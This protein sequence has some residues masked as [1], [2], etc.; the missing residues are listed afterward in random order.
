MKKVGILG[1]GQLGCMLA[2]ALF[3]WGAQVSF[4]DPNPTSPARL[5][6]PHFMCGAWDDEILLTRFFQDN[7]VVTYEFENVSTTLL[8]TLV[9]KTEVPLY[10]SQ[11]VLYLTQNRLREKTF[12]KTNGLPVCDFESC[13]SY[14]E[15]IE[16]SQ[17]WSY[18]YILKT[19]EGG[20]DGK[21]QWLIADAAA[22]QRFSHEVQGKPFV[23]LIR[24]EI[25]S[26]V[27]EASV[28]V[29]RSKW[30]EAVCFPAFENV[31][32][33]HILD[34]TVVPAQ[35]PMSVQEELKR[36]A[37]EAAALLNVVGLLTVEF[38]IAQ[39]QQGEP[40]IFVNEFAPRPHNSGHITRACCV[41][42]Q[43]DALARILLDLPLLEPTLEP[44]AFCMGNLLG[45]VWKSGSS[46]LNLSLLSQFPNVVD[47][48]LYGKDKPQNK[49]KMGH[50]IIRAETT[51]H[52]L[53]NAQQFRS[54]LRE[55]Q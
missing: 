43:F 3:K 39:T 34:T 2:E 24:E 5:R 12:L 22:V 16:K 20:Y 45:D 54:A 32:S 55:S 13:L 21:G 27:K 8:S 38:F 46:T 25:V 17:V 19:T 10:P 33:H 40:R 6:T 7:D 47:V 9:Q 44:G 49:R 18:P 1:G 53:Q 4:Y 31:H 15:W 51:E 28:I 23:P 36:L 52:A 29:A 26:I 37:L 11:E 14:G 30:G 41:Q 35:I 48:V 42:S 50:F